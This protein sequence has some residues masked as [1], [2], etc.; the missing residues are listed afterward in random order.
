MASDP[1]GE[2][3]WAVGGYAG[4]PDAAGQGSGEALQARA[5]WETASIWR[6]DGS[7]AKLQPPKAEAVTPSVADRTDT[8]S[9]A[10]FSSPECRIECA[11]VPDAQPDVNLTAAT[12]QIS[13]YAAQPGGPVFGAVLGGNARGSVERAAY[14]AGD[15]AADFAN[16]R[17]LAGFGTVPVFAA[18]GNATTFLS[19]STKRSR[20]QAFAERRRRS[21]PVPPPIQSRPSP[22]ARPSRAPAADR[23]ETSA[24]TTR[25]TRT[26]TGRLCA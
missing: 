13:E 12:R 10:F 14:E 2:H 21:G 26:R 8:V 7:G 15:G 1:T 9:F 22:P 5:S 11:A 18:R 23:T 17:L 25:S 19:G 24:A 3:A 6:Y 4:T 16:P 20:G